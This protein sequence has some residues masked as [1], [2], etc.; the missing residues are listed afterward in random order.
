[1]GLVV[2]IGLVGLLVKPLIKWN[3]SLTENTMA[4]KALTETIKDNETR[5]E[6]EH[7][8]IWESWTNTTKEYLALNT[9]NQTAREKSRAAFL[10]AKIENHIKKNPPRLRGILVAFSLALLVLNC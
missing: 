2:L 10:C 3:V 4:T 6:K 7:G 5:N 1:M 8:E 9:N